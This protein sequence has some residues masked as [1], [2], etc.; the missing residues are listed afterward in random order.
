[1]P[2]FKGEVSENLG[3]W[4]HLVECYF[5]VNRLTEKDKLDTAVLC[6]EGALEWY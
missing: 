3:G 1:M 6:L 5:V 4:L 2:I